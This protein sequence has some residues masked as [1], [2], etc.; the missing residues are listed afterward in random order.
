VGQVGGAPAAAFQATGSD[1]VCTNP[2]NYPEGWATVDV[3]LV[4]RFTQRVLTWVR[5]FGEP[6]AR[7]RPGR[8]R[9]GVG[10]LRSLSWRTWDGR[11]ARGRGIGPGGLPVAVILS[12]PRD[13]G[14]W[15]Y[16]S[17]R[18]RYTRGVPPRTRRSRLVR[19]DS[20]CPR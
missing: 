7:R 2:Q 8:L 6:F 14:R 16:L 20:T 18:Y 17:V 4:V 9:V 5:G 15:R 13:C 19:L 3:D 11:V 10:V 1:D 12:R